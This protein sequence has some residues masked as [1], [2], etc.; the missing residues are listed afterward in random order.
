MKL[1]IGFLLVIAALV[2]GTFL[3]GKQH[4]EIAFVPD[5]R[6]DTSLTIKG[7][8]KSELKQILADFSRNYELPD[9]SMFNV[10]AKEGDLLRVS[11]PQDIEPRLFLFLINYL[12]YP[13]NFDLT[14]KNIR[15][16]GRVRL[17]SGYAVNDPTILGTTVIVYVPAEDMAFDEVY[18]RDVNGQSYRISFTD[19]QW[20][21]TEEARMPSKL[22]GI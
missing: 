12:N 3:K 5:V 10:E 8:S 1:L 2:L 21:R 22:N 19:L 18:A 11:F 16:V 9:A 4:T 6:N 15:V 13:N 14:Q 17:T 7:W 20:R